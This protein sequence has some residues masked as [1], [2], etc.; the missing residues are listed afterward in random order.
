MG[1]GDNRLPSPINNSHH[2]NSVASCHSLGRDGAEH[3]TL[4]TT[5]N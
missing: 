3:L 1:G 4:I 5:T 2:Q